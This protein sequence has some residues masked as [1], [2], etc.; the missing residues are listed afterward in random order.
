MS[1]TYA[2]GLE[3]VVVSALDAMEVGGEGAGDASVLFER[4][5][6]EEGEVMLTDWGRGLFP[7]MCRVKGRVA[8]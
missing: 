5:S 6:L 4:G 8:V 2:S 7:S 1:D 3:V